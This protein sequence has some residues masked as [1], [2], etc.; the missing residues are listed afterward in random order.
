M[1]QLDAI[2]PPF[3][4]QINARLNVSQVFVLELPQNEY[5]DTA[6]RVFRFVAAGF[7]SSARVDGDANDPDK[8]SPTDAARS[9]LRGMVCFDVMGYFS[10]RC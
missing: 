1:Q 6:N 9:P 8:A 7:A 2:E 10:I 4:S 3:G 5:V